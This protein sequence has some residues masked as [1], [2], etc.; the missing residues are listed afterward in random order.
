MRTPVRAA[1]GERPAPRRIGP[2]TQTD[3]VRFAGAGGDFNPLHHDPQFAADAGFDRP[4]AMGQW[5]AGLLAAWL[6][7]WC[8]VEHLREFEVRFTAPLLIGDRVELSGEVTALEA[9]DDGRTLATLELTATR[10]DTTLLS[11][12]AVVVALAD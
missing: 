4:I 2:V 7:D 1:L 12:R 8:G 10:E 5:T 11:G 3:I 6:T 9:L